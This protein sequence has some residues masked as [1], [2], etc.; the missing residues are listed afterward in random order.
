[1]TDLSSEGVGMDG[2]DEPRMIKVRLQHGPA[3]GKDVEV[4]A[5]DRDIY[6]QEMAAGV[7]QQVDLLG[8]P[9]LVGEFPR[10]HRYERRSPDATN[11]YWVNPD[12][13]VK[14]Q[15]ELL[16]ELVDELEQRLAT[17]GETIAEYQRNGDQTFRRM[18]W[19][20]AEIGRLEGLVQE[21]RDRND[22]QAETIH[23]I[24]RV[25]RGDLR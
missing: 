4:P 19:L 14:S 9:A 3:A 1:M 22:R 23:N 6:W 12:A 20:E 16:A 15:V 24:N 17:Q 25:L 18:R 13:A 21:L 10:V 2:T 7:V 8:L 5:G 11:A